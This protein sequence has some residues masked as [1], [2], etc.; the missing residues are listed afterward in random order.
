[1]AP[2]IAAKTAEQLLRLKRSKGIVLIPDTNSLYNGT[3]HWLLNIVRDSSALILPFVMSLTQMQSRDA[4]LKAMLREPKK[5]SN[6]PQALRS[7]ALVNAGLGLLERNN[8]RYQILEMDPSLLRYM[9]AGAKS[10]FDP[11]ESDVL[12]DRLLIEGVHSILRSTRTRA[13][14]LVVTSDVLLARVLS[15]E[16]I[17]IFVCRPLD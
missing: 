13:A 7:R 17:R 8:H 4:G 16:G 9:R 14:Q 6:L 15:A 2:K 10:G 11:D 12:E 5:N 3:L 1:M